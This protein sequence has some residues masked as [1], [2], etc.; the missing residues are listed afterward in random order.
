MRPTIRFR[1]VYLLLLLALLIVSG[2]IWYSHRLV[3]RLADKEERLVRFWAAS[4]EFLFTELQDTTHTATSPE[5]SFLVNKLIL[6]QGAE[7]PL[8]VPAIVVDE[9]GQIVT[10]SFDQLE[11]VDEPS[12][13]ARLQAELADMRQY[14]QGRPIVIELPGSRQY[15]YYRETDELRALRSYPYL[16]L[17]VLG[18]FMAMVLGYLWVSQR[19]LQNKLWV[20]L[21]RETAHQ[22]GTPISGLMAWTELLRQQPDG[23]ALAD[24]MD[25]DVQHLQV[26]AERFSKIG[27]D[28]KLEPLV[29]GPL[30]DNSVEYIRSRVGGSGRARVRFDYEDRLPAGCQALLNATLF[31]WVI[32]N[33]LKNALDAMAGRSGVISLR[34]WL[35]QHTLCIEVEDQGRGIPASKKKTVFKPGYTTKKR[36][37]GLGLSLARRIVQR[38]FGGKIYVL[39]SEPDKGTVFRIE[40]PLAH[41]PSEI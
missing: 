21:A 15:L 14:T 27:S 8:S 13:K 10:H 19:S 1:F 32:E 22:L 24:E 23:A 31:H 20:G 25:R 5:A 18:L 7:R 37:W 30:L 6:Q 28:P 3:Q 29:V 34:A 35:K 4:Y 40:L 26:I 36:G 9:R 39:H 12:R 16:M 38:F 17:G 33:L 2:A 11:T 41:E